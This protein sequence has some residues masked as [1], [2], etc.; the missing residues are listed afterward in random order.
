MMQPSIGDPPQVRAQHTEKAKSAITALLNLIHEGQR[1]FVLLEIEKDL[2][3]S[4]PPAQAVSAAID[5]TVRGLAD[6][7]RLARR[8][9]LVSR[10]ITLLIVF[11]FLALNRAPQVDLALE[12][13]REIAVFLL[14]LGWTG[15]LVSA[16]LC[17]WEFVLR[18]LRGRCVQRKIAVLQ[19]EISSC[20][21]REAVLVACEE[22][23]W[24][25]SQR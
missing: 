1:P 21:H 14:L 18:P 5:P 23:R 2:K 15:W 16:A 7:R 12:V 24:D 13:S 11:S 3:E 25:M 19:S 9:R 17:L 22:L 20:Y 4:R 8:R 10:C 6:P